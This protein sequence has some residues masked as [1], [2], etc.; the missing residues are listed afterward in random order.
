V[1]YCIKKYVSGLSDQRLAEIY[2]FCEDGNMRFF[3]PCCCLVGVVSSPSHLH[4]NHCDLPHYRAACEDPLA[5][6]AENEYRQL[7]TAVSVW[8]PFVR[9]EL[10]RVRLLAI[11]REVMDSRA[12]F[13]RSRG[14]FRM[15]AHLRRIYFAGNPQR[16]LHSPAEAKRSRE[17][18]CSGMG[19]A[20]HRW[21]HGCPQHTG[22]APVWRRDALRWAMHAGRGH[23]CGDRDPVA[24]VAGWG[25]VVEG[26]VE[27]SAEGEV[28]VSLHRNGKICLELT[29]EDAIDKVFLQEMKD[30]AAK[31][32]G[33]T[34]AGFADSDAVVVSMEQK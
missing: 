5:A 11:L 29:P 20:E 26:N 23:R 1:S 32:Q 2:A 22:L 21:R 28:I 15:E 7:G 10:R 6:L 9:R 24:R 13:R 16:P 12:E 18:I 4:T 34:L 31:G 3:N 17:D 19:E 8:H 14:I 25:A 30:R 27:E 33:V